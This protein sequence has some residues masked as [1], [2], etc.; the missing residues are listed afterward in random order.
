M[1]RGCSTQFYIHQQKQKQM[2]QKGRTQTVQI[3]KQMKTNKKALNR[4][5]MNHKFWL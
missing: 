3:V 2:S 4:V 1:H 5:I